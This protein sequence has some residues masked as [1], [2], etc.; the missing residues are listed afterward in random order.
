MKDKKA[1]T[2]I[3]I[4]DLLARRWSPR[5]LDPEAEVSTDQLR[6]L[7]EA[8]RWAPSCGNTQ[9]TRYL[10]GRRGD[11]TYKRILSTLTESNQAWAHRAGALLVGCAVTRN[12]K[13]AVPMAE[14]G[15]GLATENLV[16]QAVAEGLAARQMTGFD[17]DAAHS[18]FSLPDEVR[19]VVVIA[20]GVA[21]DAS[22]FTDEQD[23]AREGAP[24]ERIAL[25][26]IAFTDEWGNSTFPA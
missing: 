1:E 6:A 24:R 7:L 14:Y 26:D 18:E 22:I 23:I 16:L 21:T 12:E 15:V 10:V 17:P 5:A 2:S 20:V 3:P 8:A 25:S 19:P 9:P 13:G 4:H 11:E